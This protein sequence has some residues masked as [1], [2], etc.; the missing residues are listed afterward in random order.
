MLKH[1]KQSHLAST[2]ICTHMIYK[3]SKNWRTLSDCGSKYIY[4]WEK[5]FLSY[6]MS[7]INNYFTII[8]VPLSLSLCFTENTGR[9]P[10]M[11]EKALN[12][13]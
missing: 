12:S 5:K 4:P 2:T 6:E 3:K 7:E 10:S 13:I 8:L 1:I 11:D 9:V